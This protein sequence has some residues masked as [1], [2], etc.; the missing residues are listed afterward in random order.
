[1]ACGPCGAHRG[2]A[3]E[4]APPIGE[5]A[6]E[7]PGHTGDHDQGIRPLLRGSTYSG[8]LFVYCGA[9]LSM[10]LL[11]LAMLPALV[12]RSAP[13][14]VQIGLTL[15][16]WAALIAVVG[17]ARTTRR[18]L[19][20][21]ARRLL[22]VPLPDPV[23]TRRPARAPGTGPAP[24]ASAS[25]APSGAD[26]WRTPLWLLLYVALGWTGGLGSAVLLGTGLALP[27][28]GPATTRG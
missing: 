7:L 21:C 2:K 14:G 5:A 9:L 20:S 24:A 23:P 13:W 6:R 8:A 26:R 4:S 27:G 28:V 11:P 22:K 3:G 16:I 12:R 17:L 25:A 15:L 19:I 10:P 18:V 1:M